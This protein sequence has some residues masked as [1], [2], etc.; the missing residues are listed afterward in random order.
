MSTT[1]DF[2]KAILSG[3]P[4]LL[5]MAAT[6]C[7]HCSMMAEELVKVEER[8]AGRVTVM[9]LDLEENKEL[10][11]AF[12]IT[13][14]PTVMLFKDASAVPVQVFEGLVPAPVLMSQIDEKLLGEKI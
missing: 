14:L 3:S 5:D 10:A 1:R 6:W 7:R 2:T 11:T 9:T 8:Y 4:V 13:S 12:G